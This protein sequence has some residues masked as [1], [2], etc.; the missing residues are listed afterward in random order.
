MPSEK[1]KLYVANLGLYSAIMRNEVEMKWLILPKFYGFTIFLRKKVL[2][3]NSEKNKKNL[4]SSLPPH[5][6]PQASALLSI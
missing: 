6:P 4:A 1:T 5:L 3:Q 2:G